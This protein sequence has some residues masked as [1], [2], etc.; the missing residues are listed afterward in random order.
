MNP[1]ALSFAGFAAL[2]LWGALAAAVSAQE[3]RALCVECIEVRVGPPVVVRGPFPDEL[4]AP[5][6]AIKLSDGQFR[7][8]SANSSTYAI[9]GASLEDLGGER[10]KVLKK[11]APGSV[12][13]CGSWLTTAL[14]IGDDVIGFVHQERSC[15][16][17]QGRTEKSMAIARSTDEGLSWTDLGTVI[18]GRDL[19]LTTGTTGEG[20]CTMIDGR[21]SYLYAY[22]QRNA[23]WKTIV[24]RAPIAEPTEW[25]KYFGGG[26][27][28]P[29]IGGE[30]TSLGYIGHSAA[31]LL[32]QDRVAVLT[33]DR[34]FGGLRLSLSADKINFSELKEPLLSIDGS[35]W[36][37]PADTDL[38]TYPSLLNPADGSNAV[39]AQFVLAYSYVP[40]GLGFESRFLVQH[41][42]SLSVGTTPAPV[43][44]GM[45]LSRWTDAQRSRYLSSTGPVTDDRL[46]FSNDGLVAYLMTREPEGAASVK[47]AECASQG[48]P[49]QMLADDEACRSLGYAR[50]RTAGWL[51]TQPQP[52]SVPVYSCLSQPDQRHFASNTTDC[53]GL[54]TM[55][56]LLGYGL[57]P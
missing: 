47:L 37:R 20:D 7:G 14:R 12:N 17:K 9:D 51:Y 32:E 34:W 27:S 26:W 8:F 18:T 42:V 3:T 50:V 15:D 31:Y 6:T 11:G 22:C 29:G 19:A 43:Q 10:R 1:N 57:A 24:A 45:A 35:D 40:P 41:T 48:P 36:N 5:L 16:Y 25:R 30:A 2:V 56:Q 54:G 23:D 52:D 44:V 39:G 55:Q 21:D 13:D 49:D 38:I 4:D 46:A 28:E 33:N 53:E